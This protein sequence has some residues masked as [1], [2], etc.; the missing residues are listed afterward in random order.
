MNKSPELVENGIA[1]EKAGLV[2]RVLRPEAEGPHPTIVMIQGHRGNEDVMWIFKQTVPKNWLLVAPRA[3]VE[4]APGS[5]SWHPREQGEWPILTKFDEAV[6]RLT[7]FIHALPELYGANLD[8]LYLMGFSQG[9][10]T[11]F[12]TAI[13]HPHWVKGIA[14]LVGFMPLDVEDAIDNALLEDIPV[15]MAVGTRD[16]RVPM[17]VAQECGK[18][19]RAM[20]AFLEYREYET[21]HKLNGEGMRKLK[22]WWAERAGKFV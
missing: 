22:Q 13:R 3:I 21:G 12:A 11:S 4:D 20:G 14:C 15:F 5:Y 17:T 18:A 6:D 8:Q 10:A 19:V 16:D 9:A 1:F 2:H 7:Q